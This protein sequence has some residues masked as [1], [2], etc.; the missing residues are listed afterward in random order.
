MSK[1]EI[2]KR[3]T[4]ALVSAKPSSLANYVPPAT[5]LMS[6]LP[7]ITALTSWMRPNI[8]GYLRQTLYDMY[9]GHQAKKNV[10]GELSGRKK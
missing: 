8:G 5:S 2:P 6:Y 3:L 10:A 1:T 7:K 4:K 9:K